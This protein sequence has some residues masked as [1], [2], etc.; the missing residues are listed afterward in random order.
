MPTELY[1]TLYGHNNLP[2]LCTMLKDIYAHKPQAAASS[3]ITTPGASAPFSMI[4]A[5]SRTPE[6]TLED[7]LTY[8][9]WT[10]SIEWTLTVSLLRNLSSPLSHLLAEDSEEIL[11]REEVEEEDGSVNLDNLIEEIDSLV[12]EEDLGLEDLL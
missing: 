2:L 3:T 4:K 1:G 7:K 6:P 12:I 8:L 9:T 11:I 10:H 5:S